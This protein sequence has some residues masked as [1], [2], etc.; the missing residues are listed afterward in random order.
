[1]LSVGDLSSIARARLDDAKGLLSLGRYDGAAYLCGYAVEMAL[2]A[3]IVKTLKWTD[4]FPE[5]AGDFG[6]LQSF[7]THNLAMLLHLSGWK[8]K[9]RTKFAVEWSN[10]SQW[11]PESRYQRPGAVTPVQVRSMIESSN[12]LLKA[13]L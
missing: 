6:G 12:R 2:K 13:L 4:G 9:I 8:A 1:V 10:V 11:D 7:K 3:R 5:G